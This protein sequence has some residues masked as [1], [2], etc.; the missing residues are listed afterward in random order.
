VLGHVHRYDKPK[1]FR[2]LT[3]WRHAAGGALE[4]RWE[5]W[6]PKRPLYGLQ[7][8]AEKPTAPAL[9][10]EGEKAA[11]AASRLLPGFAVVTSPNGSKSAGRADWSPLCGRAVTI[12]R[13]AD[14]SGLDYAHAVAKQV[15]AA[16]GLSVA[17]IAPPQ[18]VK[19]S[20]DAADAEL[21]GWDTARAIAMVS[22]AKPADGNTRTTERVHAA[23]DR[24]GDA[25]GGATASGGRRRTPQRDTLIA[26]T[27]F[28]EL[29]HDANRIAY[30]SFP[31]KSH[32]EHWEIR[33]RDFRMWLSGRYY[34][35]T[36]SAIGGQ[37]LEDGIRILEARAVNEG[38]QHEP[39][40]RVGAQ[41]RQSLSRLV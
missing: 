13:D 5:S 28:V 12:W 24:D 32:R 22:A 17:I 21:D 27:E 30:A 9:I 7:R 37:A 35:E 40:R 15:I 25:G 41:C 29:W 2:P 14:R 36:G 33:S 38:P 31:V 8:L 4:W 1:Q 3:L 16:G 11:D 23:D 18:G 20:W 26:L 34:E 10:T 19:E 6:P 39:F